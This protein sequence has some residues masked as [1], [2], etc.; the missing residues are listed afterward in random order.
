MALQRESQQTLHK[1]DQMISQ[2]NP[3]EREILRSMQKNALWLMLTTRNI[4]AVFK[5][6]RESSGDSCGRNDAPRED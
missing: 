4:I 1:K 2:A 3:I 5:T 6:L